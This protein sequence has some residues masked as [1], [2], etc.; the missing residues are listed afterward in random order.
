MLGGIAASS[1]ASRAARDVPLLILNNP[2]VGAAVRL[3]MDNLP[4][5]AD[6]QRFGCAALAN[7]AGGEAAEVGYRYIFRCIVPPRERQ[8]LA[9]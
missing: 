3:A 9:G 1:S 8:T 4:K 6:V 7:I 5:D 2:R